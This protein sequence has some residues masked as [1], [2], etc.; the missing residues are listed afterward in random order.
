MFMR[1]IWRKLF[2][3]ERR[4]MVA[5]IVEALKAT[6]SWRELISVI[7]S[8]ELNHVGRTIHGIEALGIDHVDYLKWRH[9]DP[10]WDRRY[11]RL[12]KKDVWWYAG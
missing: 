12:A 3:S 10:S 8:G 6:D 2:W 4:I 5:E 11:R 9:A 7:H 1:A